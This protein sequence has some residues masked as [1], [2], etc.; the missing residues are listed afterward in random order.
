MEMDANIGT[1]LHEI[2]QDR[3]E[4]DRAWTVDNGAW[5]DAYPDAGYQPFRGEKG[6]RFEGGWRVP[7][8]HLLARPHP[9]ARR[10][11]GSPRTWTSGRPPRRWPA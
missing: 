1:V 5:I 11:T 9:G 10:P 3:Q 6:P 4:H 7:D 8:H 2:R